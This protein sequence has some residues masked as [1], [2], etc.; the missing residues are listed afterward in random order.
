V[1][2][3]S[4]LS[5][6]KQYQYIIR[7]VS[8]VIVYWTHR[9][10]VTGLNPGQVNFLSLSCSV[11]VVILYYTKNSFY[12]VLYVLNIYNHTSFYGLTASGVSVNPTSQV[13]SSA[14]LVLPIVGN[15][16]V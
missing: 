6:V 8:S 7:C 15:L 4:S 13:C 12:K 1:V 11:H 3:I 9:H 16:K 14:M 2:L 10:R 5:C